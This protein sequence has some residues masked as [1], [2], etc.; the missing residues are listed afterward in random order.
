VIGYAERERKAAA[1]R[2]EAEARAKRLDQTVR[3]VR[4]ALSDQQLIEFVELI[5]TIPMYRLRELLIA[6]LDQLPAAPEEEE[7]P[8]T[9]AS[10]E[11]LRAE[12]KARP[13]PGGF[14]IRPKED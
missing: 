1:R 9:R 3:L 12:W 10:V 11:R 2:R 8:D 4:L 7:P 13:H 6:E 5:S 14:D